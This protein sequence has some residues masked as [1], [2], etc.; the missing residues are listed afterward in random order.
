MYEM[1]EMSECRQGDR[2]FIGSTAIK[3][4]SRRSIDLEDGEDFRETAG[5][6]VGDQ[7]DLRFDHTADIALEVPNQIEVGL[8]QSR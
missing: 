4:N 5:L 7:V 1:S 3:L 8:Q 6:D 2:R